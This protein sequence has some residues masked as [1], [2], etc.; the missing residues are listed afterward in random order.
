MATPFWRDVR[1]RVRSGFALSVS[2][3]AMEAPIDRRHDESVID[4]PARDDDVF[5]HLDDHSRLSGHMSQ[6]SWMML[7]S[8][9][10]L[11]VDEG[12]G[13]RV[14]S[15]I[16]LDGKVLGLSLHVEEAVIERTPPSKKVW[17]TIGDPSLLVIGPYRMGF[18][19][20]PDR[21]RS[22]L[23]VFIDYDL[24]RTGL[25]RWLGP[26]LGPLYAQWCTRQ[27]AQDAKA[28]F[29]NDRSN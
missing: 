9:M 17:E 25:G 26:L 1:E 22:T 13:Q 2:T 5:A 11:H 18:E 10:E 16:R 12:K 21:Q 14:G 29:A 7:G 20:K 24:P 3:K 8:R 6:S 28:H 27:M 19:I 15:V 4:L 23:R